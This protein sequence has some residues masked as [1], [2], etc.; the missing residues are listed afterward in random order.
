MAFSI[1]DNIKIIELASRGEEVR[2]AIIRSLS[3]FNENLNELDSKKLDKGNLKNFIDGTG[4]G[5]AL[6]NIKDGK[7]YAQYSHAEAGGITGKESNQLVARYSHAEGYGTNTQGEGSHAE[8]SYTVASGSYSHSEG[9]K[10]L[11]SS[12]YQ[13]VA[14][15]FNVEDKNSVYAEI[16]GNGTKDDARSN[17]RTLD[18]NGNEILKGKLTLGKAPE[19]NF[20]AV[21][22]K[23][24]DDLKSASDKAISDVKTSTNETISDFTSSTTKTIS[25]NKT[26]TDK[27]ISDLNAAMTNGDKKTLEDAEAYTDKW[28][29]DAN[30]YTDK[31]YS[32]AIQHADEQ[33][34]FEYVILKSPN[35]SKY[36][37]TVGNDG[38]LTTSVYNG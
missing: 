11:A 4:D 14:G 25:D 16:I 12:Q 36:K 7:A 33:R 35:G 19:K 8:G 30:D 26:A 2:D 37:V 27:S 5:S 13:H 10:T 6:T 17:A 24:V 15:K 28:V 1:E 22:K 29:G 23:Y 38:K 20:D 31:K 21:T 3:D 34:E 9:Y 32:A 18:W